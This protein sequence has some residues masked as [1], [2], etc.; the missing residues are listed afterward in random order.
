MRSVSAA[1]FRSLAVLATLVLLVGSAESQT[2]PSD[3]PEHR[4]HPP[5]GL[6]EEQPASAPGEVTA[7]HRIHPPVG[8]TNHRGGARPGTEHRLLPPI[9]GATENQRTIYDM[10]MAWLRGQLL[11]PAG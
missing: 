2:I 8:T 6:Q 4:I 7:N 3:P 11:S 10:F 5:V 9:G 1:V